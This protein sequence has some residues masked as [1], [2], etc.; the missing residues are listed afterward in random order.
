VSDDRTAGRWRLFSWATGAT[1]GGFLFGYQLGVISGALLFIRKE[2]GLGAFE[3]GALVSSV[4]LGAMAGGIVAG[5][6]ADA[7][8]R[9]RA[10]IL[11]ALLFIVATLLAVA[12]PNFGWLLVARALAGVAVGAVSSTGPLY[13]SEIAPRQL[14]GGL[15]TLFQLMLTLGIVAAYAV[16]LA[17]SGSGDWRAMFAMGLVP[18]ALLLGGMLRA[19]ETPVWLATHGRTEEARRILL[20]VVDEE[21]AERRLADVGRPA[22]APTR[23]VRALRRSRAAPALA[24]GV[25]L[26]AI[27]Q[28][29]G[30]NAIIAYAPTLLQ[31]TGGTASNS[32]LY[33]L[34]IGLANLVATIIA[35]GLIDRSGRRPLLLLSTAGT[36]AALALLGLSFGFSLGDVSRWLSLAGLLAFTLAFGVGLGPIFW[37]LISEIFPPE[38][39][40]AGAGVATAVNWFTSFVVG[41]VFAPLVAAIGQG[42]TFWIFAAICALGLVFVKRYVPETKGRAFPDIDADLQARLG[43]AGAR[44]DRGG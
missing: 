44:R 43:R 38:A 8:G 31:R 24:V 2:F 33:S 35:V 22:A 37:L 41:L 9:R 34:G 42:A 16:G 3:Q 1:F 18:S 39:R 7:V 5:R 29:S 6:V 30:V 25:V 11:I 15:V 26:A 32:L 12:A 14:R 13:L 23:G 19:P 10:L 4:L 40:A 20:Q 27:Q 36:S 17:F 28:L 21:E